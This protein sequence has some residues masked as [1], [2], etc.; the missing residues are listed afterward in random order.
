M[1]FYRLYATFPV[2]LGAY[3]VP[4][5]ILSNAFFLM[6]LGSKMGRLSIN[7]MYNAVNLLEVSFVQKAEA[8]V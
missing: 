7:A 8:F 4:F 3:W 5:P 1:L 6:H 2:F